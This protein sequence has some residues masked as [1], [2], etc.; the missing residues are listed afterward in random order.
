MASLTSEQNIITLSNNV[1]LHIGSS[2]KF[3]TNKKFSMIYFDP[4]FNSDRDYKLNCNSELGF[5]DKWTDED[6]EKFI[7]LNINKLYDLLENNP[8]TIIA[9]ASVNGTYFVFNW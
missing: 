6:Y 8:T 4:P 5:S 1:E 9:T 7:S 3:N 2:L